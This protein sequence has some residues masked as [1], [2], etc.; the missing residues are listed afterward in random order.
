MTTGVSMPCMWIVYDGRA[1]FGDTDDASVME[2]CG[3]GWQDLRQAL[4]SWRE[5][6]AVLAEYDID[7]DGKTLINERIIGHMREGRKALLAK[8]TRRRS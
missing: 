4:W 5:Y 8:C 3:N 7:S 2:A 1:E 6:D